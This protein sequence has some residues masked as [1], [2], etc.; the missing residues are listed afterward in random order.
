MYCASWIDDVVVGDLTKLLTPEQFGPGLVSTSC[1]SLE[2]TS[3]V[4]ADKLSVD[5]RIVAAMVVRN[6]TPL[7][8]ACPVRLPSFAMPFEIDK[9][10]KATKKWKTL[11]LR[12]FTNNLPIPAFFFVEDLR[13]AAFQFP[14]LARHT[15]K[16]VPILNFPTELA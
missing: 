1:I 13:P 16:V 3:A 12:T 4:L 15:S 6:T 10:L 7:V 14:T 5:V 8:I 2:A 11:F 9:T